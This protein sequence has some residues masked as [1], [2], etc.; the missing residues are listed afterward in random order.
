MNNNDNF[1]NM[2]LTAGVL[3]GLVS[4]LLIA[5]RYALAEDYSIVKRAYYQD[6]AET[7]EQ[8]TARYEFETIMNYNN[9]YREGML[10]AYDNVVICGASPEAEGENIARILGK[11]V[12]ISDI[13][14]QE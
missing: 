1:E 4:G 11:P 14:C 13:I 12:E 8:M 7:I 2:K 6:Q 9:G 5:N 3:I 10:Y